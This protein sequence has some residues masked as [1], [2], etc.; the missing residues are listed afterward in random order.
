MGS[1][2]TSDSTAQVVVLVVLLVV[3]LLL[4]PVIG[5]TFGLG[6]LVLHLVVAGIVGWLADLIV[7]GKLPWGWVGAV[8]AGLAGSWLG[9]RLIGHVGPSP[10]GVPLIPAFVGAVILAFAIYGLAKLA[11]K[12]RIA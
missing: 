7:P 2:R 11:A 9:T 3:A 8:L 4:I 12:D 1:R 10:F 5:F 6:G